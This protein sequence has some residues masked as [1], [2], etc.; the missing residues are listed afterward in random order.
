MTAWTCGDPTCDRSRAWHARR[1]DYLR[2]TLG[3]TAENEFEQDH[4]EPDPMSDPREAYEF[5]AAGVGLDPDSID[6]YYEPLGDGRN[7]E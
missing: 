1:A 7:S 3:P 5:E 6:S 4:P 2:E